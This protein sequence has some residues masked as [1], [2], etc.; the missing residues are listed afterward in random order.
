[1]ASEEIFIGLRKDN[2]VELKK[3]LDEFMAA[4]PKAGNLVSRSDLINIKL[5]ALS[6]KDFCED[7]LE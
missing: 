4:H 2:S 5:S 3:Y 7:P 6:I 1:M